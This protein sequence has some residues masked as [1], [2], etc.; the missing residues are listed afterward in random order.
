MTVALLDIQVAPDYANV[1]H[2]TLA[3]GWQISH[4]L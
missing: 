2:I 3:P 1:T 4:F